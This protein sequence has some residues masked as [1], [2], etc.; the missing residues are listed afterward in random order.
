MNKLCMEARDSVKRWFGFFCWFSMGTR[1]NMKKDI[2]K[3]E[4]CWGL[5]GWLQLSQMEH[6]LS[7]S[8][9]LTEQTYLEVNIILQS[10]L[11][12]GKKVIIVHEKLDHDTK[13]LQSSLIFVTQYHRC[14]N[15]SCAVV[16]LKIVLWHFAKFAGWTDLAVSVF[17][18]SL[19]S[20]LRETLTPAASNKKWNLSQQMIDYW[21]HTG[22]ALQQ[23]PH[24][25]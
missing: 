25:Q 22:S 8:V 16:W 15:E 17:L 6:K 23:M 21:R 7:L 1:G 11:T 14:S 24:M 20:C 2:R 3:A 9:S 18:S 4:S 5:M 12:L 13:K 10:S 19:A